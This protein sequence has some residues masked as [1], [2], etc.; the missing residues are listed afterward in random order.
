MPVDERVEG[1]AGRAVDAA[2]QVH[3]ALGPGL[4]ESAYEACLAH[5]L[6]IR[7]IPVLRQQFLPVEYKGERVEAG[8]RVDLLVDEALIIEV[9]SV[10]CLAPIHTA[11]VLTYLRLSGLRL[12]FLINFNSVRFK[13]GI[14]RIVL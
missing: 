10:D 11:Q 6:A 13:E 2:F 1:L 4:L 14:K 9:K 8:Y 3:R 7:R 5:E 12:G